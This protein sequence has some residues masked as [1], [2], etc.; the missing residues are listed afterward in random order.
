M[1]SF[2]GNNSKCYNA[3]ELW[4]IGWSTPSGQVDISALKVGAPPQL[5]SIP[6]Q[7]GG[8]GEHLQ[9]FKANM[10]RSSV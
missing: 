7:V 4:E 2:G 10:C 1:G 8:W 6:L 5:F 3:A 9:V